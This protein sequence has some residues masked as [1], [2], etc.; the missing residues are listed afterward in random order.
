[1]IGDRPGPLV[2]PDHFDPVHARLAATGAKL[3]V[4]DPLNSFI[5]GRVDGNTDTQVRA[6]LMYPLKGLAE[7]TGAAVLIVRH[8][9]KGGG[10]AVYRGIGSIGFTGAVRVSLAAGRMPD[11]PSRRAIACVKSNLG[12]EPKGLE[13][14][15]EPDGST[16][17]VWWGGE[18]EVSA[19]DLLAAPDRPRRSALED[20]ELFLADL[21]RDG[22]RLATECEREMEAAEFSEATIGRAKRALG[23]ESRR[24]GF[25]GKVWWERSDP[26]PAA[27]EESIPD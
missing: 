25:Q 1:M 4:L 26:G 27:A 6:A 18:V 3:I 8:L 13:Y 23:V 16:S 9:N 20:A 2:L 22:P 12:P 17:R 7:E 11:D 21:L 10:K 24:E 15:I 14:R 5:S 19:D